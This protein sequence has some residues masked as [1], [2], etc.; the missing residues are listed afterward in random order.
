MAENQQ[1]RSKD[2]QA[3]E[4]GNKRRKLP[5]AAKSHEITSRTIKSPAFSYAWLELVSNPFSKIALDDLTVRSYLTAS[6][7][8]F[9]GLMGSAI[10][11]DLL[12]VEESECWIRVPRQDLGAVMAG[13]GSWVG[14]AD[15]DREVG[16]RIK[17][18][19]DWL[20]SLVGGR[21]AEKL[22]SARE[23]NTSTKTILS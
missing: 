2:A 5:K 21:N 20:G 3:Q 10:S 18:S 23:G 16:W 14:R 22:W 12:K 1:E 11:V 4:S 8:Q 9:L 13:L 15:S 17:G 7:T 6:L 19:S